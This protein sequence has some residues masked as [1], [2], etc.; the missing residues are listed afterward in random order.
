[1]AFDIKKKAKSLVEFLMDV[2]H[3]MRD[4]KIKEVEKQKKFKAFLGLL[5]RDLKA[6]G[7]EKRPAKGDYALDDEELM[8]EEIGVNDVKKIISTTIDK[9][10][11]MEKKLPKQ[12]AEK[13]MVEIDSALEYA[14]DALPMS[15]LAWCYLA[16]ISQEIGPEPDLSLKR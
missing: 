4:E 15:T 1:M 7:N 13:Q 2:L 11:K 16:D 3:D 6:L 12:S 8:N 10:K 14:L 5:E 9:I